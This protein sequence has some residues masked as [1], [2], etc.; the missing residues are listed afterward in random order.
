MGSMQTDSGPSAQAAAAAVAE[1]DTASTGEH[2]TMCISVLRNMIKLKC[3]GSGS[4]S[5]SC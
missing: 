5:C 3:S 2:I 1:V 4:G